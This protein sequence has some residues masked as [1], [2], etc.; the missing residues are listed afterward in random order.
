MQICLIKFLR[1]F[2]IPWT[3]GFVL[4]LLCNGCGNFFE[5]KTTEIQ[6]RRMLRELEQPREIP[7]LK[8]PLPEMYR[9]DPTRVKV[10]EGVKLFY[11]TKHHSVATLSG[12]VTTQL[13]NQVSS[14]AATN[15]LIINCAN[16]DN[17]DTVLDYLEQVDV[18]PIQVNIDCMVV[19]QFADVTF[20]WET[21]LVVDNLLGESITLGGKTDAKGNYLPTFPGAALREGARRE[22]GLN[23]G[24]SDLTGNKIEAIVDLLESRG[25]LKILMNP[26]IETVNGQKAK[27]V[28]RENV[29]LQKIIF[30]PGQLTPFETT[31][32]QW[33]EDVLEVTP[34]VYADG[35]IGLKTNVKIGSRSKPEG[36]IQ[37][38]VITERN[39]EVAE[40]RIKPG[41]SLIIAGLRKSEKRSVIRGVPFMKDLPL[42]GIL[43]S[44]KD[45][46]ERATEIIFILTPSISAGGIP[47]EKMVEDVREMHKTPEYETGIEEVLTDPFGTGVYREQAREAA[48]KAQLERRQAEIKQAEAMTEVLQIKEELTQSSEEVITEKAKAA[49]ALR[50]AEQAQAQAEQAKAE[51]QAAKAEAQAAKEASNKAQAEAQAAKA[52][53]EAE[54]AQAEAAKKAQEQAEAEKTQAQAE[55]A[56][57]QA[58]AEAA[59][60]QAQE[61]NKARA[62]AEAEKARAE[63]QAEAAKKAQEQAEAE[64]KENEVREESEQE[65]SESPPQ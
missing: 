30:L 35:S 7:S 17:A 53:A 48:A 9:S 59:N 19:E 25:Y 8:N 26:Q 64:A 23:V 32:Y 46:E 31:E 65:N 1:G 15:Q 18:P 60:A 27:I 38:S 13:G 42:V 50:Q 16:D 62:Q 49:K 2:F 58:E 5:K 11:F 34:S 56:K 45:F 41:D 3:A 12:L 29:P 28:S 36:V 20:D 10:G 54:K 57:K 6:T 39:I 37:V 63:A 52:Q 21:T 43:F 14:N 51:A 55:A 44:S 22:F 40:N 33:V 24:Y 47:Y 61:A 4:M